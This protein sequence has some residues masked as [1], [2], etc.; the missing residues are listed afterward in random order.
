MQYPP[1][2]AVDALTFDQ[3]EAAGLD[4]SLRR[5]PSN[6]GNPREYH[7]GVTAW[8]DETGW[9]FNV[10]PI[11]G[12]DSPFAEMSW[13]EIYNTDTGEW[14]YAGWGDD[15]NNSAMLDFAIDIANE[16]LKGGT[17]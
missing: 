13:G 11:N 14:E 5:H 3:V 2:R 7:F 4:G 12:D 9:H 1:P 17:R 16:R 10:S 15:D 6:I 8:T